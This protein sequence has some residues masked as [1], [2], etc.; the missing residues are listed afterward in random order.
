MSLLDPPA[1]DQNQTNPLDIDTLAQLVARSGDPTD[2][3]NNVVRL[4]QQQFQ[5]DVCS[6]YLIKPDRTN[7]VLAATVGLRQESV[8]RVSMKLHEG[9]TGLAAEQLRPIVCEDA[10]RHP[11]FKYF[12]EAGEEPYKLFAG[13]P[14]LDQGVIQGVL[15]VQGKRI[16][17]L[18]PRRDRILG[19][20]GQPGC[21]HG[22]RSQNLR[23]VRRAR[24]A[25]WRS[26]R[27]RATCGGAG[28]RSPN[29]CSASSIRCAGVSSIT[30][31]SHC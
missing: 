1:M 2:T 21:S 5:T 31:R 9:L 3:L 30:T 24:L 12:P 29:R 28:T 16:A 8:G 14:L 15:V 26:G 6:I 10:P 20:S 11:R 4:I 17:Q 19:R 7:L 27:W 18:H 23:T 25:N 22:Q 13:V